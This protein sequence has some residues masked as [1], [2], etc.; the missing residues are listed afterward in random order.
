MS[1]DYSKGAVLFSTSMVSAGQS[2]A[3]QILGYIY[4]KNTPTV[5]HTIDA[6]V[7]KVGV[8]ASANVKVENLTGGTT[9]GSI[10]LGTA[11]G[12]TDTGTTGQLETR[13]AA[14][15]ARMAPGDVYR[16]VAYTSDASLGYVLR[17][18]GSPPCF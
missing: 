7:S 9:Y 12:I 3:S 15:L 13:I 16:V 4:S 1:S 11:G 8:S 17:I 6:F 2:A 14:S 10:M 5:L 18:W